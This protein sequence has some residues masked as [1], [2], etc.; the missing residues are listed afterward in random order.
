[1]SLEKY[2]AKR[3][4][5]KT[6]EPAGKVAGL[7]K[8]KFIFVVHE[9][10][11]SRL[12][13]DLRLEL[14]GV[15]KS[16]AVPK[17]PSMDPEAH[18]LAILVEDHPFEYAK[19]HGDIPEGQYGAGHVE[20]WDKGT[21]EP[22]QETDDAAAEIRQ[23]IKKGHLTFILHGKKLKGEFALVKLHGPDKDAWLLIKKHDQFASGGAEI[24]PPANPEDY[25]KEFPKKLPPN[26]IKPMLC[27]PLAE[28]F[29]KEGWLF[30]FKWD[31]FRAIGQKQGGD[32]RLYSRNNLDFSTK[33]AEVAEA[34][35]HLPKDVVLDGEIVVVDKSGKPHFEWLQDLGRENNG[36]LSYYVFDILWYEGRDIRN[37]PLI[38]RKQLLKKLLGNKKSIIKFG[39][40][41]EDKGKALFKQVEKQNLEG[42]VAKLANSP[43]RDGQRTNDW[44]KIKTHL[45]Q[46]VVIGGYTE[47]RRSRKYF[48]AL[49]VGFYDGDD[50]IYAGHSG[51]GI[52]DNA[53]RDL[54]KKLEN[55]E[56]PSSPFS[57][58]P[59]PNAPVHWVKPNLV[60]EMSF[61]EWTSDGKMRQPEF[62]GLRSDKSP[63]EVHR[64][65]NLK[66]KKA[67]SVTS[68]HQKL[69]GSKVDF[70]HLDKIFWPE[71]GYT[72]GDL[73]AY[74]E[75]VS[76]FI[77]PYL[78]DRPESLLRQPDGWQGMAF[79]Q[80]DIN[81]KTPP[82]VK[83]HEIYSGSNKGNVNYMICNNRDALFY[84]VQLG[85]I[86]INP[87]SSRLGSL[88]KPDWAVMDLDPEGVDFKTVV[89][90]AQ[91][92][93]RV[94]EEWHVPNYAK[95]SGKTGI[96]I[97]IPLKA[98]YS[99]E[100]AKNFIH[101]LAIE[102][103]K[104]LPEITSLERL[105]AKRQAKVYL[106]YL[107]NNEGQTLSAP[108]SVRPTKDATVSTPLHWDEVKPSL[109][110][111]K[112]TIK[113]MPARLKKLGDI[114]ADVR[115]KSVDLNKILD[116]IE[117]TTTD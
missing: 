54:L 46:E 52:A 78:K 81:F 87:W 9:H 5:K 58:T 49:L 69:Y 86:E 40:H 63:K 79:F 16:W 31:G 53:R 71:H 19:F 103:N 62:E 47:P 6:P 26:F 12:H 90:V 73:L 84:M 17:G 18:H 93:H 99:Y 15:L 34:L 39:D 92:V 50:L 108:Y 45:R 80:K 13:Y 27:T 95:T 42:I 107:Q 72:K 113:N 104:R 102:V 11:A 97:Y 35:R 30:E 44:F 100:Q 8:K 67:E 83:T 57:T 76:D 110:P 105:P 48:G 85:S 77:L 88:N 36:I 74:Y 89:K 37:M 10:Q 115:T 82:W 33:F 96:H 116:Q 70:T 28:P 56:R 21:Y 64:E 60:C 55:L 117:K 14:D 3:D 59:K 61:S 32:V 20:I 65:I 94:C 2:Q 29:N 101:L 75:A 41:I 66:T 23:G 112:F 111:Q 68:E 98:K 24:V 38:Q 7:H 1:M 109:T 114:W 4:F 22:R 51:G 106:D 91:T 25:I 43:Y